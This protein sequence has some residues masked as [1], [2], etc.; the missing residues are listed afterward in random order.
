MPRNDGAPAPAPTNTASKPR[1]CI[2][3]G[4]EKVLPTTLLVSNWTPSSFRLSTSRAMI[5]RGRRNEGMPYCRTPPTTCS[6]SNTVAS[7]PNLARSAATASP[8]GPEPTMATL[9]SW[10]SSRGGEFFFPCA[11]SPMKRSSRPIATDSI[12]V[13]LLRPTWHCASHC[14]SCGQTRPQTDGNRF[15]S[16]MTPSAPSRSRTSRCR[17][18]RGMSM[19]TGQPSMQVGLVHMMQRSASASASAIV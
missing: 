10:R 5:S 13:F 19:P 4:I 1:S 11:L 16:L 2:S 15:D 14:D 17:M 12:G 6:A 9:P 3:C 7:Q 18:K 8:D